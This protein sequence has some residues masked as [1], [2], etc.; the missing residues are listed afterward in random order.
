MLKVPR[1]VVLATNGP[2]GVQAA[3]FDCEAVDLE[4]YLLIPE[5]SDHLFN[6]EN[7]PR[8]TLLASGWE[9]KG[10]AQIL[11]SP[12][13]GFALGLLRQREAAWCVLVRVDPCQIQIRREGGWGNSETID[14]QSTG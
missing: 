1:R 5:T 8:V 14:L 7:H 10:T 11:R 4:L 2:C 9:M 3:E 6:L 13:P 12:C